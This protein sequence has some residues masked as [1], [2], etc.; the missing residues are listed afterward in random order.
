MNKNNKQVGKSYLNLIFSGCYKLTQI[1]QKSWTLNQG[2]QMSLGKDSE[3]CDAFICPGL[4][5]HPSP[6]R[7]VVARKKT[8]V[9]PGQVS[10]LEGAE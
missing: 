1:L 6:L 3:L 10:V 4:I 8:L 5:L 2:T 9:L 7:L